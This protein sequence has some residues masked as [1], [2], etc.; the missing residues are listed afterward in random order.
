MV[1]NS[2]EYF[3]S[4]EDSS[5]EIHRRKISESSKLAL[6]AACFMFVLFG[7]F[8]DPEDGDYIFLRKFQL[9]TRGYIS[10]STDL[11]GYLCELIHYHI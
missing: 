9:T 8:F 6:V 11:R 1:W 10:E 4:S 2:G 5:H 3:S 7:L